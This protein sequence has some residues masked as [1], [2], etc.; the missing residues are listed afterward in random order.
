MHAMVGY[1]SSPAANF[2][3]FCTPYEMTIVIFSPVPGME[4]EPT[5]QVSYLLSFLLVD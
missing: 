3:V 2:G 4:F 1:Y 5:F